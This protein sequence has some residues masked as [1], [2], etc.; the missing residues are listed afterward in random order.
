M[1]LNTVFFSFDDLILLAQFSGSFIKVVD[2]CHFCPH[3]C[4]IYVVFIL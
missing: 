2:R 1:L 4:S 3:S